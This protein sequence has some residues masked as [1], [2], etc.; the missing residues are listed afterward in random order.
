MKDLEERAAAEKERLLV[1][2]WR[3]EQFA[4]LGFTESDSA[5]LAEAT[6]DLS[7]MR[8]LIGAGCP[9]ETAFRIVL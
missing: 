6:A 5:K 9:P 4:R 2:R 7:L 1:R 8:R 3:F